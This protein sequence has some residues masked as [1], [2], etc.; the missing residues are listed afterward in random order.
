MKV[1][2]NSYNPV[3]EVKPGYY[4]D[5][6]DNIAMRSPAGSWSIWSTDEDNNEDWRFY[7]E[8]RKLD[9]MIKMFIFIED[10]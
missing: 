10:L 2:E 9:A 3:L 6:Y 4:I 7:P 8:P 5:P 1:N